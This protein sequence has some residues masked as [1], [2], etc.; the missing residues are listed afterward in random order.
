MNV[1]QQQI[2]VSDTFIMMQKSNGEISEAD[3]NFRKTEIWE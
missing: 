3:A 1:P 2:K